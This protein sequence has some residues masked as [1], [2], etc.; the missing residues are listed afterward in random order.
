MIDRNLDISL[1]AVAVQKHFPETIVSYQNDGAGNHNFWLPGSAGAIDGKFFDCVNLVFN[2]D[3]IDPSDP[4]VYDDAFL[5]RKYDLESR[6]I[7]GFGIGLPAKDMNELVDSIVV[8]LKV[9]GLN[10]D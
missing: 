5:V 4:I 3:F 1:V 2:Q 9:C 10:K 8:L 7:G 6:P